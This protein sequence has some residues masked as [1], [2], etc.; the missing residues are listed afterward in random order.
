MRE[1]RSGRIR[2]A[3]SVKEGP[4]ASRD[5][6][7]ANLG[8]L[9]M[10]SME[11]EI[12]CQLCGSPSCQPLLDLGSQPL[13]NRFLADESEFERERTYP[14]NVVLCT[15][16]HLVQL[17]T[18]PPA[19]E[20]FGK[21]FNYLSG[22]T[23]EVVDHCEWLAREIAE[24]FKPEDT[25]YVV[26]IGSNDGTFLKAVLRH[27]P[28]VLGVEPT[29]KPAEVARS[30][31]IETVI[32]R[33]E[34][35][36]QE[37]LSI[38]G[39]KISILS[40]L[41]VIA[42]TD[43]IHEFMQ[44]VRDILAET[45]AIFVCRIPYLPSLIEHCEYDTIYH[46]H[47]R[48]F[49]L[50]SQNFLFKRYG[51]SIFDADVIPLYGGSL[52]TFA[53]LEDRPPTQR[54]G[55]LLRAEEPLRGH[56]Y[57]AQFASKVSANRAKLRELLLDAKAARKRIIGIGAPMKASTL[58]NYCGIGP[59]I[60]DYITE[61]NPLK[62]GTYSPGTHIRVVPEDVLRSDHPD[63]A[64]ILSWNAAGPITSKLKAQGFTGRFLIPIPE[65]RWVD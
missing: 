45:E 51:I 41:S 46:E 30:Q 52:L 8:R 19:A 16:C 26:D 25:K 42:H 1:G 47:A 3:D 23:K 24:R 21:D 37:V 14:L 32:R 65:P 31:G 36:V 39:R 43:T 61:V 60:V 20:V 62:V 27:R 55:A 17:S 49:S 59:N 34:E 63:C 2:P 33:F 29:R 5:L 58:L 44:G 35:A 9:L 38:T 22:T 10:K 15:K 18:V 7:D 28:H 13:C 11:A 57:Y 56:E 48:Y 50:I 53:T 6:T 54:M 4:P 40:A 64:L 12:T